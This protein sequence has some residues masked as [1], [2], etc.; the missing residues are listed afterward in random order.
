MRIDEHAIRRRLISVG[1]M[2][3][4]DGRRAWERGAQESR[5][6]LRSFID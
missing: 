6:F 5:R 4:T 3:A 2:A 1:D